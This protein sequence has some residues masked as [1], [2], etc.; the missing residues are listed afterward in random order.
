MVANAIEMICTVP[1]RRDGSEALLVKRLQASSRALVGSLSEW[2]RN[3]LKVLSNKN[4]Y[5]LVIYRTV[6]RIRNNWLR[7]LRNT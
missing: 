5:F 3:S 6:Y 1:E 4:Q 2:V 7:N